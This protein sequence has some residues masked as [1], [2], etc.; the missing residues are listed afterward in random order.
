M[1]AVTPAPVVTPTAI[2]TGEF[3]VEV[4]MLS[5]AW[6]CLSD[7]PEN[8]KNAYFD[9]FLS[10]ETMLLDVFSSHPIEFAQGLEEVLQSEVPPTTQYFQTL[11]D[12][13][14]KGWGVYIIVLSKPDHT[15]RVYVG[16]ATSADYGIISRWYCYDNENGIPRYY[17]ASLKEGFTVVSR[18]LL[19]WTPSIPPPGIQPVFRLLFLL[20][21][22]T[23]SY[24]FWAM[25]TPRGN[26]YGMA[27]ICPW[28]R[29]ALEY[30][31]L[32]SHCCLTEG[33]IGDFS[34]SPE[35]LEEL[36][37]KKE[38]RRLYLKKGYAADYH[39][40]QMETNYHAY[41]ALDR[42]RCRTY[43]AAHRE[44]LNTKQ[45]AYFEK[46]KADKRHHCDACNESSTT[47]AALRKHKKLQRHADNVAGKYLNN[48]FVCVP[49]RFGT[50]KPNEWRR[51]CARDRH[52][53]KTAEYSNSQL[54]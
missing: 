31:G 47:A 8:Q 42:A 10:S 13:A 50:C 20:L 36:A 34:L 21:E 7:T 49:C 3:D 6:Q 14:I 32:C 39:F 45:N 37:V 26:D 18:G 46:C 1:P 16:S 24:I 41:M 4:F 30:T 2:A 27:H 25:R 35:Q 38:E 51:H 40:K 48:R 28:D 11:S 23:F 15:D 53:Q 22:A 54:E 43:R 52:A 29:L 12:V 44:E 33:V 17:N 9:E 5:S 19:C